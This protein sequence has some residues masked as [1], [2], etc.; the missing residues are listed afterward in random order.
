M[1]DHNM[2]VVG[3]GNTIILT[4]HVSKH[5]WTLGHLLKARLADEEALHSCL[6][7]LD[8]VFISF[9]LPKGKYEPHWIV[10]LHEDRL[11]CPM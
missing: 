3:L 10:V 8:H 9:Y 6:L 11:L 2:D 4:D 1:K 7:H 5:P